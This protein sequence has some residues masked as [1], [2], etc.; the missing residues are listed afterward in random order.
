M[1]WVKPEEKS[2]PEGEIVLVVSDLMK[3]YALFGQ[4]NFFFHSVSNVFQVPLLA[5]LPTFSQVIFPQYWLDATG[6]PYQWIRVKDRLPEKGGQYLV[7]VYQFN[8]IRMKVARFGTSTKQ[9][10]AHFY[11]NQTF[12][13]SDIIYWMPLPEPPKGEE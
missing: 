6:I 5:C 12:R 7:C 13:A 9:K 10:T 8:R 4:G 3:V 2:P 11:G 1:K